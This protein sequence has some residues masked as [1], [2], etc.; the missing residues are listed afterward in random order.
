MEKTI[1]FPTDQTREPI[2]SNRDCPAN[3]DR[4]ARQTLAS[5]EEAKN[6][7]FV[8]RTMERASQLKNRSIDDLCRLLNR[9]D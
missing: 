3:I 6:L 8:I 2:D 9:N 5:P 4:I 7:L 1:E